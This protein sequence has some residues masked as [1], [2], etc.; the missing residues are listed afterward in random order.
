MVRG[1]WMRVCG[2]GQRAITR[3][4]RGVVPYSYSVDVRICVSNRVGEEM[5]DFRMNDEVDEQRDEMD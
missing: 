5:N 1:W 2:K 4:R 3:T